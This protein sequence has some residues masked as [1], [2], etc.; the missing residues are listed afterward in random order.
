MWPTNYKFPGRIDMIIYFSVEKLLN[1][2]FTFC[3]YARYYILNNIL[4]DLCQHFFIHVKF[5]VLCRYND[6]VNTQRFVIV[7]VFDGHLALCIR[8]QVW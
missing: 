6:S 3:F 2:L 7:I 4:P 8:P 1:I 5:V